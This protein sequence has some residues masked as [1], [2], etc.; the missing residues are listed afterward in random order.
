M[1]LAGIPL[2]AEN[3]KNILCTLNSR[4]RLKVVFKGQ[5]FS[6]YLF[7]VIVLTK[8]QTIFLRISALASQ[9]RSNQKL[10]ELYTYH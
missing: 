10:N 8:I 5:L 6:Q 2:L 9:I 7:G 4:Y 1:A 3:E